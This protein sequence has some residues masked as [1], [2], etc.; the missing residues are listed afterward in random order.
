MKGSTE[1]ECIETKLK[2]SIALNLQ[3]EGRKMQIDG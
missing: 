1:G 2:N 3:N